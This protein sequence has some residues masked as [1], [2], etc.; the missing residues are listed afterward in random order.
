[1]KHG[2]TCICMHTHIQTGM[3][4]QNQ[5]K[6]KKIPEKNWEKVDS[7]KN[8]VCVNCHCNISREQC[9]DSFKKLGVKL[10]YDPAIPLLGT[11]LE[12]TKI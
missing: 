10:P 2:Q 7:S 12:E 8:D 11:Y 9:E 1:M 3:R 4:K 5:V 6:K